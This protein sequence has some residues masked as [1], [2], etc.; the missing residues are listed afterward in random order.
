VKAGRRTLRLGEHHSLPLVIAKLLAIAE[1]LA[2]AKLL[3]GTFYYQ[4]E[5]T[6]P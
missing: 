1:L 2:I 5:G 3:A 4:A 6:V